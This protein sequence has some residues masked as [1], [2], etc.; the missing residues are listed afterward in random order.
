M[1]PATDQD[2]I[3]ARWVF[4]TAN[5]PDLQRIASNIES[6]Y[7]VNGFKQVFA[8]SKFILRPDQTFDLVLFPNYRHGKWE[9][10]ENKL[11]LWPEPAGDSLY[12][13]IDTVGYSNLI[14][15]INADNFGKLGRMAM[16]YDDV[17]LFSGN[18]T[19]TFTLGLDKERYR[20]DT[21][22]PY[23]KHNNWWRIKPAQSEDLDQ[24]KQRVLNMVDFHL[25]VFEDAMDR[26]K[27]VVTY[28]WFTSPLVVA[29]NGL[30]L[31]NYNKIREDWEQCFYDSAQARY[32]F[33]LLRTGF[34]RKMSFPEQEKNPFQRNIRLLTDF[35]KNLR[36]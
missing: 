14:L 11:I 1:R 36:Q 10:T 34:E 23:S 15:T 22:D 2:Y 16:P 6:S 13:L 24:V 25:L 7:G 3:K 17:A 28:N 32:G 20:D 26:D 30:A 4:T 5:A 27:K 33:L 9:R 12:F 18:E 29:R 35:R 31:K 8:G 19:V 21:E